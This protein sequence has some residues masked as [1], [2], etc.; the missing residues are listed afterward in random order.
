MGSGQTALT[1]ALNQLITE[2]NEAFGIEITLADQLFFKSVEKFVRE[3]LDITE[4]ARN[5]PRAAFREYFNMRGDDLFI[6]L[7]AQF[8]DSVNKVLSNLAVRTKVSQ[9]LAQQVYDGLHN[10]SKT[11]SEFKR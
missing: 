6:S 10:P 11:L 2:L 5:K 1:T 9:R 7:F 3:N 8:G 4:A